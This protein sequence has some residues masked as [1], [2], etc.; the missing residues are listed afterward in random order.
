MPA[1]ATNLVYQ[2]KV[3]LRG[4]KPPIWRRLLVSASTTLDRLHQIIQIAMGWTD[5]HLHQFIMENGNYSIPGPE[6]WEPVFDERRY[7]LNQIVPSEDYKFVYEYDFGDSWD[8][9]ILVEKILPIESTVK[10]PVCIKG[11]RAC[12]PEDVG[13]VWGY[14]S[15]LD[16]MSDPNHKEHDFYFKWWGD[17]FD[18]DEFSIEKVNRF[19]RRIN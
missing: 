17:D 7:R 6:D 10:Y 11:K 2:L 18:P 4:S 15:F 1:R 9:E 16:A 3:T 13:G 19:L 12:P 5:S 14:D 8:H